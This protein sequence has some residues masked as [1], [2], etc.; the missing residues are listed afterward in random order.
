MDMQ[1]GESPKVPWTLELDVVQTIL[2]ALAKL[3]PGKVRE[4][5]MEY[6]AEVAEDQP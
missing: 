6:A 2:A 3:P 5:V 4:R 1:Q